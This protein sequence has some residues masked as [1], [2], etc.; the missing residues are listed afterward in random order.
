MKEWANE[1]YR[2]GCSLKERVLTR[3]YLQNFDVAIIMHEPDWFI[4]NREAF[5]DLPVIVRTV[6]QSTPAFEQAYRSLGDRIKIV[7]NSERE[8]GLEG[9]AKTDA[10][11]YFGK[12]QSDFLPWRGGGAGLTFHNNYLQREQVSLPKVDLWTSFHEATGSTLWGAGN[13]QLAGTSGIAPFP[14]MKHLL[15][16]APW[17]FYVYSYPP[18]YTLSLMEAMFA[19]VPIIAPSRELASRG[20][21]GSGDLAWTPWRY[22]VPE[23]VA[24]CGLLYDSLE[25]AKAAAARLLSD[26]KLATNL[27][28]NAKAKALKCFD[29]DSIARQWTTFLVSVAG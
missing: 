18:S 25:G 16:E 26:R 19:G 17:Y 11:I 14:Q 2:S 10:V 8:I 1:F 3:T 27:S 21:S 7:R 22:E 4:R 15:A 29:A 5:G 20:Y 23:I 13:E 24:D 28:A 12:Y 9:F 6:G